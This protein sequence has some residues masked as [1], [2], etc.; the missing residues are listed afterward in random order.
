MEN[1]HTS[2]IQYLREH[3]A[4]ATWEDRNKSIQD[5]ARKLI[6]EPPDYKKSVFKHHASKVEVFGRKMNRA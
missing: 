1:G 3:E 5:L 2:C 4:E 6:A